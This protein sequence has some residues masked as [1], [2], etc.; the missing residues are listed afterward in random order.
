MNMTTGTG[1][2]Q[3]KQAGFTLMETIIAAIILMIGT[4]GIAGLFSVALTRTST[5]G[6][7]ATRTAEYAQDKMEEL[8]GSTFATLTAGDGITPTTPPSGFY[9]YIG[10]TGVPT[11]SATGAQYMRRWKIENTSTGLKTITVRVTCLTGAAP[12][13]VLVSQRAQNF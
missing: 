12:G 4:I 11:T 2:S 3:R 9:D 10:K 8:L 5:Y 13:Y 1:M 6:D 7:K